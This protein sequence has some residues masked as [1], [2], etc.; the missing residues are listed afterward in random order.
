MT[1]TK[2]VV[3]KAEQELVW[4]AWTQADKITKWFAP[5]AEID[6]KKDGKFE[7]YWDLANDDSNSTKGCK[8]LK[9]QKPNFL[10][11]EW[12]GPDQLAGIMNLENQLTTVQVTFEQTADGTK[13]VLK[14]TGWQ[15]S[16]SWEKAKQWHERAWNSLFEKLKSYLESDKPN[17]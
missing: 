15:N 9:I 3:I 11:F 12:K 2:E 17:V 16:E 1:I 10:E 8:I 5:K 4:G 7:L 13:I 6:P 14:H